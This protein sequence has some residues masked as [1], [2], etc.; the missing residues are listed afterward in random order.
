MPR[1]AP[2][3]V[4][5]QPDPTHP[6]RPPPQNVLRIHLLEAENLVAK[7]NFLGGMVR[8][9]SD[10]YAKVRAAGRAFRSRVVKEELSPRWNEV[11]EV[12]VDNVPGQDV[13][14]DLFDK[15]IDKDD[16]LGRCKVPLRR[17]LSSRF[18][19]E[20]LPLEEVKSG[21]LH[22]RLEI[23]EP[24]PSAALLEQ[25]LRT[26][27]LIQPARGEELSAALLSVFVDR[28]ADLLVS[29]CPDAWAPLCL[30]CGAPLG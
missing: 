7:D 24:C 22:V 11:Y 18:V 16:F 27:S 30:R 20:W 9:K 2:S 5:V 15:D 17:V 1:A 6:S 12:I 26:N 14:F 19:D 28:A 23:L 8:G 25:V 3:S 29:G 13:E 21:R 10:P 4:P